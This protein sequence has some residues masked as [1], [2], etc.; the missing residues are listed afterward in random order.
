MNPVIYLLVNVISLYNLALIVW[1]VL[2]LLISFK[3]VNP[4]QPFVSKVNEVLSR[5]IEPALKP[6][7]KYIPPVSGVDLSPIVLI[8]LLRFVEY[9]LVY[10]F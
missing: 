6:I 5:L 1:F 8:L 2:G 4:Y 9:A 7:R 10:Y 3:I